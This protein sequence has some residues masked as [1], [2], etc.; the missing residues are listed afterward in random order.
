MQ[1]RQRWKRD[2]SENYRVVLTARIESRLQRLSVS[3]QNPGAMPQAWM[4]RAFGA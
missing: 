3:E 2:S 4:R 1:K